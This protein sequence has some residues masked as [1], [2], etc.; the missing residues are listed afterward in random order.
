MQARGCEAWLCPHV[1][2]DNPEGTIKDPPSLRPTYLRRLPARLS[3]ERA[4][5][6]RAPQ[7]WPGV[8][9]SELGVSVTWLR[10]RV[11]SDSVRSDD[12]DYRGEFDPADYP[13]P[14]ALGR[15]LEGKASFT[16]RRARA[17]AIRENARARAVRYRV[18]AEAARPADER[19]AEAETAAGAKPKRPSTRS[20]ILKAKAK[21]TARAAA[22]LAKV[23]EWTV[24]RRVEPA[25]SELD[26][27]ERLALPLEENLGEFLWTTYTY[28]GASS[29]ATS[30]EAEGEEGE[31]GGGEG[32]AVNGW[33][34][35]GEQQ[36]LYSE[37]TAKGLPLY[38]EP[39]PY[40]GT[41][42][43]G[44]KMWMQQSQYAVAP[45]YR[46][47]PL[48]PAPQP[49][50]RHRQSNGSVDGGFPIPYYRYVRGNGCN[51]MP[52]PAHPAPA[53]P[54]SEASRSDYG[55]CSD[56]GG[57]ASDDPAGGAEGGA[58]AAGSEAGCEAASSEGSVSEAEAEFG[59]E[60]EPPPP[61]AQSPARRANYESD[62]KKGLRYETRSEA[63]LAAGRMER[64][65]AEYRGAARA[66]ALGA[67]ARES[68]RRGR[69]VYQYNCLAEQLCDGP[70]GHGGGGGGP[71]SSRSVSNASSHPL[72][73]S[74]SSDGGGSQSGLCYRQSGLEVGPD[75]A[76]ELARRNHD[77][78][79]MYSRLRARQMLQLDAFEAR[80]ARELE[81]QAEEFRQRAVEYG[82]RVSL[83]LRLACTFACRLDF[84]LYA[85]GLQDSSSANPYSLPPP[86]SPR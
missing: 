64:E 68:R 61:A 5:P 26:E 43:Y 29:S 34:P 47:M 3:L 1:D 80:R 52:K 76:G 66:A 65:A 51:Y 27:D 71:A 7:P 40:W 42:A 33:Q 53:V 19:A 35:P 85:A 18:R 50:K 63:A 56:Y 45:G 2:D 41:E 69:P 4:P 48:L 75:D 24:G 62:Y 60:R 59:L 13:V 67:A 57:A 32:P 28:R 82:W 55:D 6:R 83:F 58:A 31:E 44:A 10:A 22:A 84:V 39:C 46:E 38:R 25:V 15:R 78:T 8:T 81:E 77:L 79:R 12:P 23:R 72:G 73:G 30:C 49:A 70:R 36:P 54:R 37:K 74:S 21:V 17:I 14:A 9:A 20:K 16:A 86:P 11:P